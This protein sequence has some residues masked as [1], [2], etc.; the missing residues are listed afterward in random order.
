MELTMNNTTYDTL[1]G[2]RTWLAMA[3]NMLVLN[4]YGATAPVVFWSP[5]SVEPGNIV[6]LYGG[7]LG[8]V[9]MISVGRLPDGSPGH[10]G[11]MSPSAEAQ[12]VAPIQPCENSLKFQLPETFT[13][14]IFQ[15][16]I[17]SPAG[18]SKPVVLNRPEVWFIQ[19]TILMPGLSA[20]QTPPGAQVQIIGK[21]FLLPG[22]KGSARA[23]M[24]SFGGQWIPLT[25]TRVE[26]F[27]LRAQLPADLAEG[28]YELW[29]HNGFGGAA[30]WGGPLVV[31]VKSSDAWPGKV[32]NVKAFGAKGDGV[33]DDT[34]AI[35]AALDA[36]QQNGGGI[37]YLPWGTYRLTNYFVIPER[38]VLRGEGRDCTVLQ[39][40]VSDPKTR[41]DFSPVAAYGVARYAV[42]D[43][44]MIARKSDTLFMDMSD[45]RLPNELSAQKPAVSR[46]VFFRRV[47]FQH[48]L[49]CNRPER[50]TE[51]W[52]T[53]TNAQGKPVPSKHDGE[54]AMVLRVGAMENFELSD[55]QMQ[56][57][58][59]HLRNLRNARETGNLFGNEMGYCWA[60]LGGG[61]HQ[62]VCESNEVRASSS[63]GYGNIGMQQV[64]S[65][66][67]RS[68]NFVRGEREG[69]T[70][71]ISALPTPTIVS[72][73]AW[74]GLP[75]R[76]DGQKLI[77]TGIKAQPGEFVGLAVMVLD[78]PGAGQYR[79]ITSNTPTEFT[80]ER[81]WDVPPTT[82][83]TVGLWS[84]MRH[85][86]VYKCE[87][88]DTSAFSQLYG[89][90]YDFT[91][92][93]CHV[94]RNQGVWGQSGWFVRFYY[95]DVEYANSYHP[96]IG[97]H[98]NNPEGNLPF[99]FVGLTDGNLRITKFGSS[100]YGKQRVFVNEVVPHPVPGG[101]GVIVKGNRLCYNQRVA[102]PPSAEARTHDD[103]PVRFVDG[104]VDANRIEHSPVGVQVGPA[105]QR[106][107][108]AN[109]RYEDVAEPRLIAKPE[110]VQLLGT[111][112]K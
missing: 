98:G 38:T 7:G 42:E 13:A 61:A 35:R 21:N 56:G 33:A 6:L 31:D 46:D 99:S 29:L 82:G 72:N 43:L 70:L 87:G 27:S 76:V 93:S 106:F 90:F 83:S 75:T 32:F 95:N 25:L 84:L 36:A 14:G 110:H 34:A 15:A 45:S 103:G 24:R 58:Q 96:G 10:P 68:Y 107:V 77:L 44:T 11:G 8:E 51:L 65:A 101:R 23:E 4:C 105:V 18:A 112:V 81:P 49:G 48:W 40:P 86:I 62:M 30:G 9:G 28:R 20:N 102:I 94:E 100:Q 74:F 78:G 52:N 55:C 2:R 73:I 63:W 69:M 71:D 19:P 54:Q 88:Y 66:H 12:S 26:R 79:I 67:N 1:I 41:A 57:G 5:D 47:N 50:N 37:V 80:V 22:D 104:V 39:W 91:V 53:G 111:E 16:T 109:N 3:L 85:M 64:Y 59:V 17:Q 108:V 60:E 97:P 89:S 92:D